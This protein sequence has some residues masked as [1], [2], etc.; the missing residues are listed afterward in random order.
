MK[1]PGFWNAPDAVLGR[2]LAPLGWAYAG[3]TAWRLEHGESWRAA[4]PVICIG[5]L[6]AGGAGKTPV[7][8]DLARRLAAAG[9][10]PAIL[11]RGYG[12]R[13]AGPLKVDPARHDAA[14][15]GDEPLMLARETPCWIARDRAAGARAMTA[16]GAGLVLMDDGLQNPGLIQDL[17][18]VV[19]DGATG[20]G[21]G[22]AMPAGPLR[23]SIAAGIARA[24]VLVIVGA[25]D[26]GLT[27]KYA[28]AKIVLALGTE[29]DASQ[30]PA[31]KVAAFA[32]IGRPEKFRASLAAAGAEIA[33]FRA[34]ADHHYYNPAELAA[35]ETKARAFGASLVT[36]EKDWVRLSPE[37]RSRVKAIPLA[38][39]W[40]DDGALASLLAR[41]AH[42][43]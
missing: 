42:H 3:V 8:R 38:V 25:D 17:K 15:V 11:S 24:D 19:V 22:R 21:N 43:G 9:L 26:H 4:V 20:F 7:V 1:A 5:N 36:T 39:R 13:E 35:L 18:I 34:F 14:Q 33:V 40:T 41:I 16:D 30:L 10:R 37:W 23:E 31:G 2:I 12:G 28:A 6:T 27:R 32:G 29:I